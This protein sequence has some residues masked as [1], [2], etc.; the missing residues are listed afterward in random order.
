MTAALRLLGTARIG[1]N[2]RRVAVLG[3]MRELGAQADALHAALAPEIENAGAQ[4]V[5]LVGEHMKALRDALPASIKTQHCADVESLTAAT[6]ASVRAGD[7]V[8]VKSSNGT[9]TA[10][11]VSALKEKYA[12]RG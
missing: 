3:D 8:M 4:L 1:R 6:L 5:L 7:V 9:G 2:G 12:L 10:K 11:V